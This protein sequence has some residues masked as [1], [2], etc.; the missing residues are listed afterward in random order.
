MLNKFHEERCRGCWVLDRMVHQVGV[1]CSLQCSSLYH[2]FTFSSCLL[3]W[4]TEREAALQS[5]VRL[6]A[7]IVHAQIPCAS[8]C[9]NVH[10]PWNPLVTLVGPSLSLSPFAPICYAISIS[11]SPFLSLCTYLSIFV[12]VF[13]RSSLFRLAFACLFSLAPPFVKSAFACNVFDVVD[14]KCAAPLFAPAPRSYC[15]IEPTLAYSSPTH[16]LHPGAL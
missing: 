8:C 4:F 3:L 9:L 12:F 2:S 7:A 16:P 6:P 15:L 5:D 10:S 13:V 1:F 14:R 11:P